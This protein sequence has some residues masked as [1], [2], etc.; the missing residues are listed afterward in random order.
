MKAHRLRRR[1]G[2]SRAH[3]LEVEELLRARGYRE[4]D[5]HA[6]AFVNSGFDAPQL[7]EAE[8]RAGRFPRSSPMGPLVSRRR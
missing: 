8:R 1:Y 7:L 6:R 5:R 2:R 4:P 3:Q